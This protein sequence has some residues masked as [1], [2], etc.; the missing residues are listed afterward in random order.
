MAKAQGDRGCQERVREARGMKNLRK[1]IQIRNKLLSH[2]HRTVLCTLHYST[3]IGVI[4]LDGA[5]I[6]S[7]LS[8]QVIIGLIIL[9]RA[10]AI[11]HCLLVSV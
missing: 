4:R 9:D 7:R 5:L 10:I 11:D 1:S 8:L 3:P 2:H 6:S